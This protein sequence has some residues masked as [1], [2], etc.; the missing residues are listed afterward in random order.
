VTRLVQ[1]TDA[2]AT[3]LTAVTTSYSTIIIDYTHYSVKATNE[4]VADDVLTSGQL[5]GMKWP[6]N[7]WLQCYFAHTLTTVSTQLDQFMRPPTCN[8]QIGAGCY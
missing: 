7:V 1:L 2:R 5:Y 4:T 8:E 6:V 3:L